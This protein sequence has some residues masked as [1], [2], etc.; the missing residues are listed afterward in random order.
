MLGR[1][2]RPGMHVS[3]DAAWRYGMNAATMAAIWKDQATTM[4]TERIINRN[5]IP[6]I[7]E[8]EAIGALAMGLRGTLLRPY[9]TGYDESR[10]LWNGMIDKRPALIVKAAGV[11]DVQRAVNFAREYELSLSIR[12]GGHNVAGHAVSEGGLMLDLSAMN[13]VRVDPD[14]QT[15]WVEGGALWRDVDIETSAF[16]L[17]T[18]G[19]AISHTGVG[20]LTLGGG[21]GWLVGKHGMSIDN[22]RSVDLVTASG[23]FVT[24]SAT[25]HPDLFW[26]LR[27]GGGNFGVATSFEFQLHPL[28]E[29]YAGAVIWPVEQAAEV[30]DLYRSF[31]ETAPDEITTYYALLT[32][33]ESGARVCALMFC[34]SG[35]VADGDAVIAPWREV[36]TPIAEMVGAMPYPI[37]NASIDDS[38]EHG[39]RYYWKS[40]L[41]ATLADE[42]CAAIVEYGVNPDNPENRV[43]I[44]HYHGAFNRVGITD[45]AYAHRDVHYQ[46]V[47]IGKWQDEIEDAGNIGWVR[48]LFEATDA[49]AKSAQFLNFNVFDTADR[50][51]RIRAGFGPNYDRLVAVKRR[52][53]P[54]NLFHENVNIEP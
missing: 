22:L 47:I 19:G 32:D 30:L 28:A 37:F 48:G 1:S 17:A 2:D 54:T 21:I 8:D 14:A 53:D 5:G 38:F 18:T 43:V 16:G 3:R 29:V 20:G 49:Y 36:G 23:Q 26:A 27:G 40:N 15:A 12:G 25:S 50:A 4:L 7:I 24:A 42:A 6:T 51:E 31:T 13:S 44:E 35:D 34:Y 45:T 39:A 10:A 33:P 41:H 9:D 46:V 52:Y 11:A